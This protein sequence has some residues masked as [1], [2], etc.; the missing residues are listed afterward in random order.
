MSTPDLIDDVSLQLRLLEAKV[1]EIELR[2]GFPTT[3][4][5]H[6]SCAAQDFRYYVQFLANNPPVLKEGK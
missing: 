6:I 2:T 4:L 3:S 1:R 5:F